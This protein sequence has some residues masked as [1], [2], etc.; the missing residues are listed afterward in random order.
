MLNLVRT[1]VR[2]I[3]H[4]VM[5]RIGKGKPEGIPVRSGSRSIEVHITGLPSD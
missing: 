1:L 4:M 5:V 3:F 2:R